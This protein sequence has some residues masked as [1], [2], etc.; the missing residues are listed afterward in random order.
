MA[1]MAGIASG[2]VDVRPVIGQRLIATLYSSLAHIQFKI[3][4]TRSL[5]ERFKYAL[6]G[7]S[8]FHSVFYGLKLLFLATHK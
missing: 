6:F 4:L 8:V 3:L 5:F 7:L 1:L 2:Y